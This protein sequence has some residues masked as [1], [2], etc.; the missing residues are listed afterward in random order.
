MNCKEN[1]FIEIDA[2]Y[3]TMPQFQCKPIAG[4]VKSTNKETGYE[5]PFCCVSHTNLLIHMQ[6]W[7]KQ[8]P[9]CCER[10]HNDY[11]QHNLDK[12]NYATLPFKIVEQFAYTIYH[13][14]KNIDNIGWYKDITDYIDYN[15]ASFGHPLVGVE[16]YMSV[17]K[18]YLE[19]QVKNEK[20]L[21]QILLFVDNYFKPPKK[22]KEQTD[23]NLL[24]HTYRK[25]LA[26]FPFEISYFA[27]IKEKYEKKL[28]ILKDEPVF[29]PYLNIYKV[30]LH[31]KSSLIEALINLT[32]KLLTEING[33]ILYEQ[34]LINDIGKTRVEILSQSRKLKLK[35]GYI[36]LSSNEEKRYI[37]ILKEW[38]KDEKQF[39]DDLSKI[40]NEKT[41][42]TIIQNAE[43]IY[44]FD[45]INNA[46]FS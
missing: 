30:K 15:Y 28:P 22:E 6:N 40:L 11:K 37:K 38:F 45:K 41:T 7:F 23:L 16:K 42:T 26:I 32:D 44:N 3:F 36:N 19:E 34:N 33:V 46:N 18:N 35:Q 14:E 10:H 21:E 1:P 24:Y 4:Y 27:T 8:Y 20:K 12:K 13:I 29:N 17:L 5:Y 9:A 2:K 43:K 31:T 25:W 39:F